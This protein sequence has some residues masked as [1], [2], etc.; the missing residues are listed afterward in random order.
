[1]TSFKLKR[2]HSPF[3]YNNDSVGISNY[4]RQKLIEDFERLS[5][6][7]VKYD[8]DAYIKDVGS[9]VTKIVSAHIN[10]PDSVKNKVIREEMNNIRELNTTD[11]IIYSKIR[12]W[13]REDAMQIV[14]WIDWKYHIYTMWWRWFQSFIW[15]SNAYNNNNNIGYPMFDGE[16][17]YD[18]ENPNLK[19]Y[20]NSTDDMTVTPDSAN[21]FDMDV[22]MDA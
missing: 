11:D 17:D 20:D 13:I 10:L 9:P 8:E 18:I 16:G 21:N 15:S 5:I 2:P 22:D 14:P 1:M 12:D 6:G 19:M 4:K 3:D 7:E